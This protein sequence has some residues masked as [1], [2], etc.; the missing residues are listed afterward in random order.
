MSSSELNNSNNASEEI[1]ITE[2][3]HTILQGKW[4]ILLFSLLS[5]SIAFI[6]YYGQVPIYKANTLIRVESQEKTIPGLDELTSLTAGDDMSIATEVELIKSRKILTKTIKALKLDIVAQPKR[7][8]LLGLLYQHFFSPDELN[9]LPPVWDEFDA[10][11]Y[12]YAWGNEAIEVTK[13]EVPKEWFNEQLTVISKKEGKFEVIAN[14]NVVLKGKTGQ[15]ASSSDNTFRIFISKLTALE[16]TEFVISKLSMR[17]AR[18]LLKNKIS[19]SEQGKKTG[20]LNLSIQGT[21]E[22]LIIKILDYIA[23]TYIQRNKSRNSKEATNALLFLQREIKPVKDKVDT[24]IGNLQEYRT[25]NETSDLQQETQVVL[26]EVVAIDAEIQKYSLAKDSLKQEFTEQHPKVRVINTQIN[27]LK[28]QKIKLSRKIAKLPTKQQRLLELERD[29]KVSNTIYLDL[30]NKIQEF[31]IAKASTVGNVYIIDPAEAIEKPI[32]PKK[33]LIFALGILMGTL[34]GLMIV[35]LRKAFRQTIDN[36][37]VLEKELGIPVYATV[38]LS[39]NVKLTT[40]LKAKNKRQKRLLAAQNMSDPAIES[41]RS[42]RTSLHFA[43]HEAKNKIVLITGPSPG[44]GK[45]FI[46][47][48]FA[49]VIANAE[50][51]VLLIDADMRRG[52]LHKLLELKQQPGLSDVISEKASLKEVITPIQIGENSIDVITRGKTPPNPSELLMNDNFEKLLKDVANDYDLILVDS[53]PVHAV[54]DPSIIGSHAGVVFMVVYASRHSLQ[55][56]EHAVSRLAQTGV[57]VKGFIFNG[58][59]VTKNGYGGY[60]YGYGY[61]YG[62]SYKE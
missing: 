9:K 44:I 38:P 18:S 51:R 54:T 16:N 53:P 24:S 48:N 45:S 58:F 8:P 23:N 41:L 47:S 35:V 39:K 56:I 28:Q 29:F 1:D 5:F 11:A 6:Y 31:K 10:F 25:I 43:L 49:A 17:R 12:K 32:S 62:S 30:F 19:A 20:I 55:E 57:E 2:I 4:L 13:L 14:D 40:T 22:K 33:G 59:E 60:G 61:G 46:S 27:K 36:P 42:L 7:I 3:I 26:G 52:Y 37:E 15:T 50:Q 21:N 34:L